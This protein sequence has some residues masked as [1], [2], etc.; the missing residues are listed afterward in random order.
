MYNLSTITIVTVIL[1][2]IG[3][4]KLIVIHPSHDCA[5]QDIRK[6][7]LVP[8]GNLPTAV[9]SMFSPRVAYISDEEKAA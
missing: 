1:R 8:S 3:R 2:S 7:R 5:R 9:E 4:N 6:W